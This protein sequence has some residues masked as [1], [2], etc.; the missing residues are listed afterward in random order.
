M[1]KRRQQQ[2]Q[3][4]GR[5]I[6]PIALGPEQSQSILIGS[7]TT[8]TT[9][10]HQ[11]PLPSPDDLAKY[12]QAFPGTGE[13]IIAMAEL[14]QRHRH[15]IEIKSLDAQIGDRGCYRAER[16]RGQYLGFSI[17][18]IALVSGT[19]AA[20]LGAPVVGGLFGA[21]GVTALVSAFLYERHT[22]KPKDPSQPPKRGGENPPASTV[23]S[24]VDR[25]P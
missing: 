25:S 3:V 4:A 23:A 17:G 15:A 10:A 6:N 24:G 5:P 18:A 13:R 7:T 8:T 21:G 1:S 11:G 22:E 14:E 9:V 16:K 20:C 12:D 2:S 19:V